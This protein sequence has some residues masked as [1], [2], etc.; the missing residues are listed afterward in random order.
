MQGGGAWENTNTRETCPASATQSRVPGLLAT[1]RDDRAVRLVNPFLD[2]L[3]VIL[4]I[5]RQVGHRV[6]D[7]GE[8]RCQQV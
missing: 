8:A 4:E 3:N 2:V 1:I 7:D 5:I 6:G